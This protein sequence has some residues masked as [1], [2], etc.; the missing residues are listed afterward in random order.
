MVNKHKWKSW[1]PR[2]C[3]VHNIVF[4]IVRLIHPKG[5]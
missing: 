5:M 3:A 2:K 4:A 1:F